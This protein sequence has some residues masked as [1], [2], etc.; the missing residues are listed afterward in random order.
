MEVTTQYA[1]TLK[2]LRIDNALEFTQNAIQKY[3]EIMGTI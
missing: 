3:P 1:T 2:V